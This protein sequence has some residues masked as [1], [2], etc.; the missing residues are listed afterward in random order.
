MRKCAIM[1]I[2]FLICVMSALIPNT[3]LAEEVTDNVGEGDWVEIVALS[4]NH[5]DNYSDSVTFTATINYSLKSKEQGIVY[6]GFNTDRP[7]YYEVDVQ[8]GDNAVVS[9][10]E[11][12][13]TLTQ[14][15]TPVNWNSGVSYMQQFLNGRSDLISDFKV[16]ANISEYP[17]DVPWTPLAIYEAV[18]TELPEDAL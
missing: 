10:G 6:L 12:T 9:K 15:V 11:G 4:P 1:R 16:Y 3:V 18:V 8:E 17:H 14:T 2:M 5:Y 13:V 7:D